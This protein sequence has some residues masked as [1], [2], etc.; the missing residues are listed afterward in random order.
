[1]EELA[2]VSLPPLFYLPTHPNFR[3]TSFDPQ[4]AI[5]MNSA[6]KCPYLIFFK[7]V[8]FTEADLFPSKQSK[9]VRLVKRFNKTTQILRSQDSIS[10][11]TPHDKNQEFE[12]IK[13]LFNVSTRSKSK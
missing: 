13:N 3:I 5:P 7:A 8:P 2:K 12:F 10:P 9:D 6:A 1:M 4:K 11:E